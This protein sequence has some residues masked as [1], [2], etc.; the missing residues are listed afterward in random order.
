LELYPIFFSLPAAG[1]EYSHGNTCSVS[2]LSG[3]GSDLHITG[4]AVVKNPSANAGGT[5][6]AG[7]VSESGRSPGVGNGNPFQ[8]SCLGNPMER[9]A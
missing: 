4:G 9:G 5:R 7:S 8:Y 6:E 3:K 1:E 2:Q